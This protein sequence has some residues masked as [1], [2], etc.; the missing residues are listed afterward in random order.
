[1]GQYAFPGLYCPGLIEATVQPLAGVLAV[2]LFP[3][4]YCPGLI[5][6]GELGQAG[7]HPRRVSGALLPRP[8]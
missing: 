1:M 7:Q 3:G 8:H 5:E 4:L 2:E 6:A